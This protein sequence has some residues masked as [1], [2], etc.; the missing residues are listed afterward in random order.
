L[1]A[2]PAAQS[3]GC[4]VAPDDLVSSAIGAPVSIDSTY[5]VS[6]N[7]SDAECLFTAGANLVLVRR[8]TGFFDDSASTATPEQLDQLHVLI[9]DDLELQARERCRRCR[10]FAMVRDRSLASRV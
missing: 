3:T 7:G 8:T 5:G 2:A 4:P 6:V 1:F 9:D 10:V